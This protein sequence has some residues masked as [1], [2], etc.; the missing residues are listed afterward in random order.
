[1]AR[2]RPFNLLRQFHAIFG[3]TDIADAGD[4]IHDAP[5]VVALLYAGHGKRHHLGS[6]QATAEQHSDDGAVAQTLSRKRLRR[7]C[8]ESTGRRP[9]GR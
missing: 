7:V 5:A 8:V 1:M 2:L 4:N 9:M 3:N 6:A